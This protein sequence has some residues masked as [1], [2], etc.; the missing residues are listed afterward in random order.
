MSDLLVVALSLIHLV[1]HTLQE[2]ARSVV[3]CLRASSL[4]RQFLVFFH[5]RHD[6]F[7]ALWPNLAPQGMVGVVFW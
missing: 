6:G 2:R 1:L 7:G 3:Y 4:K 5:C